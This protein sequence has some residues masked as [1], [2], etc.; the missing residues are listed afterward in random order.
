MLCGEPQ[1]TVVVNEADLNNRAVFLEKEVDSLKFHF[2]TLRTQFEE[3]K[4][5]LNRKKLRLL[6]IKKDSLGK[7]LLHILI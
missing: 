5:F 2:L 4:E 7:I 6:L 1:K 3:F